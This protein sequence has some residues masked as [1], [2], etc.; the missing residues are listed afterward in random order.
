MEARK[1]PVSKPVT[2]SMTRGSEE[3]DIG[4]SAASDDYARSSSLG[5][6][7]S[8]SSEAAI[9]AGGVT[10]A[11]NESSQPRESA[12]DDR[13]IRPL[14]PL[15]SSV[16]GPERVETMVTLRS[17]SEP[18]QNR[19]PATAGKLPIQ[20]PGSSRL[21]P[22]HAASSYVPTHS[23]GDGL[24]DM[25]TRPEPR[26]STYEGD[27]SQVSRDFVALSTGLRNVQNSAAKQG[28][29]EYQNLPG[30][31][32][33]G[34]SWPELSSATHLGQRASSQGVDLAGKKVFDRNEPKVSLP[35]FKG[36]DEWNVFWL[37][38]RRF[39]R[40]FG[41]N[42]AETLDRLVSCLRDDALSYYA[43]LPSDVQ[44]DLRSTIAYFKRRFDDRRLPETYRAQLQ[45]THK[46]PK[47]SLEEY[48]A[49]VRKLVSKAFPGMRTLQLEA[50]TVE[51]FVGGLSDSTM[52]YD[53]LTKKPRTIE[54]AIDLIQWHE[55][56]RG[57]QRRR[58]GVRRVDC[59]PE[60]E[61][62][63][64]STVL[65]RIQGKNFVTEERLNQFGQELRGGLLGDIRGELKK[66][67]S[68]P[69]PG[70]NSDWKKNVECHNCHE[71][72]HISR[73]CPSKVKDPESLPGNI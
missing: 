39:A 49:R 3:N 67:K 1:W 55:S 45:N 57:I 32:L 54:E 46:T 69:R 60:D 50:M 7:T 59:Q 35:L 19:F 34:G 14:R 62:T 21:P 31:G 2:R 47:E 68:G 26:A 6:S 58:P 38:F 40:R 61:A 65:N 44:Y 72:G 4:H 12:T 33:Q 48:A 9:G 53:V 28:Y 24:H 15:D 43:E 18:I 29:G 51:Y 17:Q 42:D 66:F 56:C 5:A 11:S 70:R 36:K 20:Q 16:S 10:S 13:P 52:I 25:T 64:Q 41:W 63:G 8:T 22:S 71:L 73:E 23:V 37:Q 30:N 27:Y